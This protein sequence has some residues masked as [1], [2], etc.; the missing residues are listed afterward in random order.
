MLFQ[1]IGKKGRSLLI[2]MIQGG[3]VSIPLMLL[4]PRFLGVTGIE[5]AQ[6][7]AYVVAAIVTLPIMTAFFRRLK[8]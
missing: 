2:A 7:C 5:I 8:Q 3:I 4:L 1:S 6:P